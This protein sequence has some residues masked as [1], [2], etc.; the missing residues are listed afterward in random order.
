MSPWNTFHFTQ[1]PPPS[2]QQIQS[3][4]QHSLSH[5]DW[6]ALSWFMCRSSYSQLHKHKCRLS[7]SH[8]DSLFW[9]RII[10]SCL[11]LPFNSIVVSWWGGNLHGV[12]K[13]WSHVLWHRV[14]L[15]SAPTMS[16]PL[17]LEGNGFRPDWMIRV[18]P[19]TWPG[20]R[21]LISCPFPET[22]I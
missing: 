9:I 1:H 14:I 16:I 4:F 17:S 22:D 19:R 21:Q 20:A 10:L 5:T 15:L 13:K 7:F 6:A 18:R 3:E 12:P 11:G 8:I 2:R